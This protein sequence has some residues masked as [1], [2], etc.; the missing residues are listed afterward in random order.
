MK[1]GPIINTQLLKD[2]VYKYLREEIRSRNL[3]PGSV[4]NM[5]ATS[6]KLGISKT[7]LRDALIQLEMEGFVTIAPR[8]GIYV[9]GLTIDEVREYYHVIG[10]LES[11][12]LGE[13]FRQLKP[14]HI[15][16]MNKLN[17]AMKKAIEKDNF[18]RFYEKNLQFHEIYIDLH[19]NHTLKQ[20]VNNL[21]RRLYDFVPQDSWIKE[22]E[23]SSILEHQQLVAA[24]EKG[25]LNE[26]LH[27]VRDVHWSFE[28][29][30]QFI[31]QYYFSSST[32]NSQ[33]N[34]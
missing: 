25:D 15:E 1:N 19:R 20:I 29:Q 27:F 23:E 14:P 21:K 16:K 12:A 17:L 22:W 30:E 11:S 9:N 7:P 6:K 26:S 24:I 28:V 8:K 18:N 33:G 5:D 13:C 4:I 10:A 34:L 3:Q 31:R 32:G 2:Q